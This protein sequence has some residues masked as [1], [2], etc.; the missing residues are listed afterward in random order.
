M[1]ELQDERIPLAAVDAHLSGEV[2]P[3]PNSV[4]CTTTFAAGFHASELMFSIAEVPVPLIR[5]RAALAI[6]L[7]NAAFLESKVEFRERLQQTAFP[8][9]LKRFHVNRCSITSSISTQEKSHEGG[10]RS[11]T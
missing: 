1:V 2:F 7:T 3:E 11:C 6:P 5:G 10:C 4:F 8:A 9:C